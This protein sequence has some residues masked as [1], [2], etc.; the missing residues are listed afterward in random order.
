M[1]KKDYI[2]IAKVLNVVYCNAY[3]TATCTKVIDSIVIKFLVELKED[4]SNFNPDLFIAAVRL[5]TQT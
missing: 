3:R 1:T 5:G 4:N 2:L